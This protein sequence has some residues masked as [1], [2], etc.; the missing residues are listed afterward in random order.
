MQ[1]QAQELKSLTSQG[2]NNAANVISGKTLRALRCSVSVE[3]FLSLHPWIKG[4]TPLGG[5]GS[6]A[7]IQDHSD[8]SSF[9]EPM[10]PWLEWIYR[11]LWWTMIGHF[12]YLSW[13][14]SPQN[15]TQEFNLRAVLTALRQTQVQLWLWCQLFCSL[16]TEEHCVANFL[17]S[18]VY[19]HHKLISSAADTAHFLQ[20]GDS[21][22][23]L[24]SKSKCTLQTFLFL[25]QLP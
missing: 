16:L 20:I 4:C 5:S 6:G 10:N 18:I 12:N 8:D 22:Y 11:L 9:K 23:S 24:L 17:I 19:Q 7:A 25:C 13:F 3:K 21:L 1:L 2:W 14:I 15:R